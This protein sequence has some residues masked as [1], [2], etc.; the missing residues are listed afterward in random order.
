MCGELRVNINIILCFLGVCGSVRV[1][2]C[3]DCLGVCFVRVY[4][5]CWLITVGRYQELDMGSATV[6]YSHM[7]IETCYCGHSKIRK[8]H[9]CN[10]DRWSQ[11]CPK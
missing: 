5:M 3:S 7:Y 10:Q 8:G 2:N 4:Y 6:Y 11:E 1:Y 9:L